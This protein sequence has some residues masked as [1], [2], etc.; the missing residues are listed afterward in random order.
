MLY[1]PSLVFGN[2][3]HEVALTTVKGILA[4]QEPV[5]AA[6]ENLNTLLASRW[7]L[8]MTKIEP[9]NRSIDVAPLIAA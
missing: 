8:E 9:I 2:I 3:I 6:Q 4:K 5:D 1:E 7:S